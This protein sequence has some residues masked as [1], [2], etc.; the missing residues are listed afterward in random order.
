MRRVRKRWAS[1]LESSLSTS[2]MGPAAGTLGCLS[3]QLSEDPGL[4]PRSSHLRGGGQVLRWGGRNGGDL[5]KSRDG[6]DD[7]G[8]VFRALIK[9]GTQANTE[10]PQPLH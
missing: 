8:F 4:P 3:G 5:H 9:A 6:S 2:P 1:F 10:G 7:L